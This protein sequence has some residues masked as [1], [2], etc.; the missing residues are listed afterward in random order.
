LIFRNFWKKYLEAYSVRASGKIRRNRPAK[1]SAASQPAGRIKFFIVVLVPVIVVACA[2]YLISLPLRSS[3]AVHRIVF[4]GNEH[5]TDEELRNLAGLKRGENLLT[6]SGGRIFARMMES[7]WLRSV[8]VRKELPDVLHILIREAEPFALLDMKGHLFIV[9]DSGR[10]LEELRDSQIPFLPIISGDPFGKKE[11]FSEAIH[12][13]RAVK[14]TGLLSRKDHIEIIAQK[15]EEMVMNIDGI[16]IKVGEGEYEEKLGRLTELEE[17]IKKRQI[18]VDYID[19]RFSNRVIVKPV[20]E[21][22]R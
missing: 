5:L 18:P 16:V 11:A 7:P 22:I 6:L 1:N 17:E 4:T 20:N 14:G 21:V 9:D 2:V 19:L 15:P 10:M 3:F 12:L 13:V 8:S